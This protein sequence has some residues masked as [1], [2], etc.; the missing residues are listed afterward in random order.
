[1]ADI[2]IFNPDGLAKT[3]G[4]YSHIAQARTQQVVFI[5]GQVPSDA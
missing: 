3:P 2:K 5:S 4:T 1:M